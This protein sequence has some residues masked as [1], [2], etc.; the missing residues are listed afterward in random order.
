MAVEGPASVTAVTAVTVPPAQGA[1]RCPGIQRR[2][3]LGAFPG[4]AV[5][6]L[7]P[8][9]NVGLTPFTA[10]VLS[11]ILLESLSRTEEN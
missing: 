2:Q 9:I 1:G 4:T 8:Y 10:S 6:T 3:P 11:L 5:Y 7:A